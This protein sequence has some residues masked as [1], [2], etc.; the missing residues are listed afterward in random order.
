[1]NLPPTTVRTLRRGLEAAAAA[2]PDLEWLRQVAAVAPDYQQRYEEMRDLC[3]H[4]KVIC[5]TC[6]T[7]AGHDPESP[8]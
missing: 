6:L 5:S 8:K 3:D 1:M 4:C 7:A 2:E